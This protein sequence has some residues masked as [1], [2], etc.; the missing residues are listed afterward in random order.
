M[1]SFYYQNLFLFSIPLPQVFMTSFKHVSWDDFTNISND[2]SFLTPA[3]TSECCA[4]PDARL[5]SSCLASLPWLSPTCAPFSGFMSFELLPCV[6]THFHCTLMIFFKPIT[7]SA[8]IHFRAKWPLGLFDHWSRNFSSLKTSFTWMPQRHLR[9]NPQASQLS[10]ASTPLHH[11]TG[12]LG[13]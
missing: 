9:L 3:P 2:S 5:S 8:S 6:L 12:L 13:F 7:W 4:A 1:F 10:Q 11:H